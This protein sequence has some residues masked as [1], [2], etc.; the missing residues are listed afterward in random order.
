MLNSEGL[1]LHIPF[2]ARKCSYCDFLSH[3]ASKDIQ[4]NYSTALAELIEKLNVAPQKTLYIGGGTPNI[5][6][7]HLVHLLAALND[8]GIH[9]NSLEEVTVELN[10]EF[11]CDEMFVKLKEL[12]VNRLSIGC[13]SFVEKELTALGRIH[14]SDKARR[15]LIRAHSYGFSVSA[16]IMLG[17]PYQTLQ[18]ALYSIKQAV[19]TGISHISLYPLQ[20]EEATPLARQSDL[21]EAIPDEDEVAHMLSAAEDLLRAYGIVRY[22]SANYAAPGFEA[23]H[24]LA[25]WDHKSYLGLGPS[26]ASYLRIDE[27]Q[28][29]RENFQ[30]L[31]ALPDQ[32][33]SVRLKMTSSAQEMIQN[34]YHF[35]LEALTE[36]Q[37]AAEF[38]MLQARKAQGIKEEDVKEAEQILP[39]LSSE[40]IRLVD[41]GL[42]KRIRNKDRKVYFAPTQ[43]GWLLGNELFMRLWDLA[44]SQN[45]YTCTC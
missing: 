43:K 19:D 29:L 3:L 11:C 42:L 35:H 27:Y 25:Y 39:S 23:K 33:F 8:R 22:E 5:E 26:A 40:L 17:I 34:H 38:F 24:N 4:H 28:S 21:L 10:P 41:D 15:A 12:G 31:P 32:S 7:P 1:Y 37:D 20:I 2:C 44:P 16:D 45:T 14:G 6:W 30:F 18:S 9:N 13:Q 36:A